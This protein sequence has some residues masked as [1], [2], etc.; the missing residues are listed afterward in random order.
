MRRVR[1][2]R[3]RLRAGGVNATVR[4]TRGT[5]IDAACGQLRATHEPVTIRRRS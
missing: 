1:E 5:E 4:Q 2:F 3:D